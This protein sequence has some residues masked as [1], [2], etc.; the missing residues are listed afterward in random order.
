MARQV[1]VSLGGA[2]S[3]FDIAKVD[4]SKLYGQR[5]RLHLDP[6]GRPCT[7]AALTEDGSTLIQ[8]GMTA[9]GYFDSAGRWVPNK[10]LVGLDAEGNPL[11]EVPSTLGVE[12]KLEGPVPPERVL[13]L[14]V[15]SVYALD[16][17]EVDDAL[18][19][20]LRNGDVY[21][22]PFNY[23]ADYRAEDA[24][25]LANDAGDAFALVGYLTDPAWRDPEERIPTFEADD[26]DDDGDLD[27][28][29]F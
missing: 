22:L 3:T 9:Q 16:P 19:A 1:I 21:A 8:S 5:K 23:R 6:E 4:R 7:R 12:Q 29:M 11:P 26:G 25:L 2:K 17:V 28:E 24:L 14:R 20:S 15:L 27:F 18:L 10:E 13:D